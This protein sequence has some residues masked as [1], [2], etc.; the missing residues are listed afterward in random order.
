MDQPSAA[1]RRA[2]AAPKPEVAP[3]INR[4]L[5]KVLSW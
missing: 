1:N 2:V 3:V 5:L 4:V